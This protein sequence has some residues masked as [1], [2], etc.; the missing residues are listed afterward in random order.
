[1]PHDSNT[2]QLADR[3][4]ESN[5]TWNARVKT[6]A[7]KA[8]H[9][10]SLNSEPTLHHV[11]LYSSVVEVF[12]FALQALRTVPPRYCGKTRRDVLAKISAYLQP[13]VFYLP[14]CYFGK[15]PN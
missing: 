5:L 7:R 8:F 14:K 15:Y 1:M 12:A 9:T 6:P 10:A 2:D 3:D 4:R 11:K 13:I